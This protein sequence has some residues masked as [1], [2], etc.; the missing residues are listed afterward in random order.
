MTSFTH[1]ENSGGLGGI[2]GLFL[3]SR[4]LHYSFVP[5]VPSQC[6][7][8]CFCPF[9]K[10]SGCLRCSEREESVPFSSFFEKETIQVERGPQTQWSKSPPSDKDHPNSLS[11]ECPQTIPFCSEPS[12]FSCS[13]CRSFPNE[14]EHNCSPL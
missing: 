5:L 2:G 3:R 11:K 10:W 6:S 8:P 9:I 13:F 1:S 12:E 7:G 4:P 14:D